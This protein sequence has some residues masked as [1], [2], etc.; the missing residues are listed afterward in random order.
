M[1]REEHSRPSTITLLS[2]GCQKVYP[3]PAPK[4]GDQVVCL[5]H[6]EAVFVETVPKRISREMRELP[7]R[8]PIRR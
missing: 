2:C 5:K 3:S 8:S 1:D 7:I 4:M 6:R